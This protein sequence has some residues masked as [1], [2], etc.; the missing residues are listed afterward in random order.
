MIEKVAIVT[1]GTGALGR[2]IVNKFAD[3][4]IKVFVPSLSLEK[5]NEVF[6]KSRETSEKFRLRKIYSF[7]CD[8]NDEKSVSDFVENVASIGNGK[9]DFLINTVGGYHPPKN[10]DEMKTDFLNKY[11][12][13]NFI[14]TFRFSR[15]VLRIMKQ[16]EYG[17]IISIGAMAGTETSPGR[18][19]YAVSKSAVINLMNTISSEFKD[20]NIRCNTI[21]PGTIDTPA[22]RE[23]GSEEDIKNW[24][25]PE[26]I[27]DIIFDLIS[28]KYKSVRE[29]LIKIYGSY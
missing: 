29:S 25:K 27:A 15:N 20:K 12:N 14:S 7:I 18:F 24:V 16:N 23:W 6:D 9:I 10:I 22:N 8:A 13:I 11:L 4:N 2:Y 28:D 19:A 5:F 3:E 26:D 21:I 17:R 1:G